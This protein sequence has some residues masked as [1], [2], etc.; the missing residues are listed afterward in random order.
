MVL[1]TT[2][3]ATSG[4]SKRRMAS[5][6]NK[7]WVTECGSPVGP[8]AP[9]EKTQ[10]DFIKS[11]REAWDYCIQTLIIF[12]HGVTLLFGRIT[13]LIRRNLWLEWNVLHSEQGA[14]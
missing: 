7:E 9:A 11:F 4:R 6:V 8:H 13:V 3:S 14:Y 12:Q 10:I 1:V 5:P 2:I